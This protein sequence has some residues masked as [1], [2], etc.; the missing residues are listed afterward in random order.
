M[1]FTQRQPHSTQNVWTAVRAKYKSYSDYI[2]EDL[3]EYISTITITIIWL[4]VLLFS[5]LKQY[6]IDEKHGSWNTP[7]LI[8]IA[9]AK[10]NC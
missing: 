10:T 3:N 2:K 8:L 6:V 4:I 7:K 5:K 9:F 1:K